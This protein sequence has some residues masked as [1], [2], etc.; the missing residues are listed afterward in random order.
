MSF[1]EELDSEAL[2]PIKQARG[3]AHFGASSTLIGHWTT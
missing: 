3:F 1:I 2:T